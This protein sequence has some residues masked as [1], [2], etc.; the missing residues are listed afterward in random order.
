MENLQLLINLHKDA[1]RQGPGSE[2]TTRTAIEL[3][4][5]SPEVP[6]NIVDIGCGTGAST[7]TLARNLN[8][9]ITAVDFLPEFLDILQ[10]NAAAQG[11]SDN[12]AI[13]EKSMEVLPFQDGEFDVIWSEGAIYNIGF[14]TGIKKWQRFLKPDGILAVSEITWLTDSRPVELESFW[15]QAY[16]EI[17]T[18]SAK[19][20]QLEEHGYT[21]IGYFVLPQECWMDNYY[22]PLQKRFDT[23]LA[24][25]GDSEEARALVAS[26]K[27]EI[28]LYER[29]KA[30][31]SYGFYIARKR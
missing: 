7:L 14:E 26:E 13:L 11:L 3:A 25:Q 17:D 1:Q 18:A 4:G 23:F 16:A 20:R 24:R 9:Q 5:L 31:Y 2:A 6:I 21:P 10:R 27:Q 30:Y 8:A 19:T 12:V 22:R 29:Y 15:Q 28:A